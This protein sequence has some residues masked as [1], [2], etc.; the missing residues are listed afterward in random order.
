VLLGILGIR[1]NVIKTSFFISKFNIESIQKALGKIQKNSHKI[2]IFQRFRFLVI[3]V[4]L[5]LNSFQMLVPSE[6]NHKFAIVGIDSDAD[7]ASNSV[8]LQFL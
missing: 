8:D 2:Y 4:F 7:C 5:K 3:S 6:F 1:F